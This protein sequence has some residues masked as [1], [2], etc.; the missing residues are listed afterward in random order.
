MLRFLNKQV[1]K[2]DERFRMEIKI[3]NISVNLFWPHGLIGYFEPSKG[4]GN[5]THK[6]IPESPVSNLVSG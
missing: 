5:K 1:N 3:I 4:A 6:D 2:N